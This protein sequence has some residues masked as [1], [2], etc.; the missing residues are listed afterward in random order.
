MVTQQHTHTNTLS[1]PY[2][3]TGPSLFHSIDFAG[4]GRRAP[5]V[6][7]HG[8]SFIWFTRWLILHPFSE[9]TVMCHGTDCNTKNTLYNIKEDYNSDGGWS[10]RGNCGMWPLVWAG[11]R[12]KSKQRWLLSTEV[13]W[14]LSTFSWWIPLWIFPNYWT[15]KTW[16]LSKVNFPHF[17][18]LL[19]ALM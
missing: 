13:M 7:S 2:S 12:Q 11:S 5:G 19:R 6:W 16:T 10:C 1:R 8:N 17:P 14:S 3:G 4:C 18:N 9:F 15:D